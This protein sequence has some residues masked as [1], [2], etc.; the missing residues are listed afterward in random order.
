MNQMTCEPTDFW[1]KVRTGR[2][3]SEDNAE[4]L[5]HLRVKN[6]NLIIN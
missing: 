5:V 1:D 4:W 6:D 2:R 3:Q